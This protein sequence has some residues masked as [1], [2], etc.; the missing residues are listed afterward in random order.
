MP[1]SPAAVIAS[2]PNLL[3]DFDGPI[4]SIF[5]T[6][7]DRSVSEHL[8]RSLVDRGVQVSTDVAQA[9]DP[10]V[11]LRYSANAPDDHLPAIESEL[12]RLEIQAVQTAPPTAGAIETLRTLVERGHSVTI[13]SN[14]SDDAV[15]AYIDLHGLRGIGLAVSSRTAEIVKHLKPHPYLLEQAIKALSADPADC[16]M[17]GDSPSDIE[18]ARRAGTAAVALVNKPGKQAGLAEMK[19]DAL[20]FGMSELLSMQP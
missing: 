10:F 19:P 14:N 4:C 6:M 16:T 2:A 17:I 15:N 5:G 1:R 12:R 20:I 7:T 8:V 9:C 18:A 11:V 13:V 3:V